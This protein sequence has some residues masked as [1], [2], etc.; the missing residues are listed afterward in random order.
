MANASSM[1]GAALPFVLVLSAVLLSLSTLGLQT[2]RQ[3]MRA[4]RTLAQQAEPFDAGLQVLRQQRDEQWWLDHWPPDEH[5]LSMFCEH[6]QWLEDMGLCLQHSV[7][8]QKVWWWWQA[9]ANESLWHEQ[10]EATLTLVV[11]PSEANAAIWARRY[12]LL[13]SEES[14]QQQHSMVFQLRHPV[15]NQWRHREG[16]LW[17]SEVSP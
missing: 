3:F 17:W 2:Q 16:E 4:E 11:Q 14:W 9:S 15:V 5:E 13:R 12:Y 7:D 1:H 10:E 8:R 6:Y